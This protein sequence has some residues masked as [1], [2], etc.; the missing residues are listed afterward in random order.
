LRLD[1]TFAVGGAGERTRSFVQ[2]HTL[3]REVTVM[4]LLRP[5]AERNALPR[6]IGDG[7]DA[8]GAWLLMPFV[9]GKPLAG[10]H[11]LP[12]DVVSTLLAVHTG[13]DE[14]LNE[15]GLLPTWDRRFWLDVLNLGER[16]LDAAAWPE[17]RPER[18]LLRD[19]LARLRR[20]NR[21][22]RTLAAFPHTLLHGDVHGDNMIAGD[23]GRTYLIDWG[24]ARVG[25]AAIDLANGVA[26]PEDPAWR[27]YWRQ[28]AV[29]AGAMP[30]ER[31]LRA[32]FS[33]GKAIVNM[34]YLPYAIA[35]R[36]PEHA[37]GM[38]RDALA[39]IERLEEA[40][41]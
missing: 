26:S 31:S 30:S 4:R 6:S 39:A 37:A 36:G 11:V 20:D 19:G 3:P 28:F 12:P 10:H 38:L 7:S 17:D 16:A 8:S 18:A 9:E 33:L 29:L 34:Q 5:F 2:K 35:T 21:V 1:V 41:L 14:R 13:F 40:G 27:S 25:P 32:G 15:L 22:P 24:N 23:D